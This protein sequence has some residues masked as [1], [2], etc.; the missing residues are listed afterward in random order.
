MHSTAGEDLRHFRHTRADSWRFDPSSMDAT[1]AS[2][3]TCRSNGETG[4]GTEPVVEVSVRNSISIV[5]AALSAVIGIGA[6]S[7]ADLPRPYTKAP[8]MAP[9]VS[10]WTGCYVGGNIGAGWQRTTT[11]DVNPSNAGS[12]S[13]AGT[14]T[15]SGIV[16]GGQVGCDYQF[17]SNW[18]VGVQGMFDGADVKGS[19][20]APFAYAGDNT[21]RFAAR[22]DWFGTLTARIG[23]AVTPQALL[24]LKGGVAWV[25]TNYS[26]ADASGTIFVP[27]T[28]V[29]S[30]TRIGWTIG[31]GGE[32]RLNQNWSLFAEYD[33]IGLGSKTLGYTYTCGAVCGFNDPYFYSE[34]QNLQTV[35]VG[36]NY[37]FGGPIVAK[38]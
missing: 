4:L 6:A 28:G 12:F 19:H 21:E 9:M 16:G 20:F 37:R 31:G 8:A 32:Y 34:K 30:S 7:A 27:Y 38:Y 29:V 33:Y 13:D 24:Y 15:G 17:A 35:L 11:T 36:L 18:V 25:H 14:D 1:P 5:S 26:D 2:Y 22:T 23:Y 10:T 3:N